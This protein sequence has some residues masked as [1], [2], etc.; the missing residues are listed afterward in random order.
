MSVVQQWW[1]HPQRVLLRRVLF[2][3][4]LW[5][6]LIFG[7]YI[8]MLSVTGSVLVYRI[9]LFRVLG[10]PQPAFDPQRPRLSP[11][12]MREAVARAYPGWTI[13]RQSRQVNRR[14]LVIEARVER[15]GE[16][17]ERIFDPYTGADLGVPMTSGQW[18]VLWL[19]N[20]HDELLFGRNGQWWNGVGSAFFTVLVLSGLVVWWPGVRRWKRS[21]GA[22]VS[23]GWRRFTWDLHS[24][25]G[26]WIFLFMLIWGVSGFYMGVPD[27]LVAFGDWI[28]PPTDE[29]RERVVDVI[30]TWIARLHF[31]R[32]RNGWLKAV[33]AIV[34]LAPAIMF[35]TGALMWWNRKRRRLVETVAVAYA[36]GLRSAVYGLRPGWAPG[37]GLRAAGELERPNG[38]NSAAPSTPNWPEVRSP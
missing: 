31:G 10:D 37:G 27:P 21:L 22:R 32:W 23:S 6:G 18:A 3:V 1:R 9:E 24:A 29:G 17:K 36:A 16:V 13:T 20:L 12:E 28:E 11:E 2:Q 26:F 35:V 19:V 38:V 34:G 4:H 25:M 33:W 14:Q 15:N 30:F 7:L 5:L 8:V